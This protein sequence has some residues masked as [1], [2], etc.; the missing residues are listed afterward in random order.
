MKKLSFSFF[1]LALLLGSG[2]LPAQKIHSTKAKPFFD[3]IAKTHK[4]PVANHKSNVIYTPAWAID[5]D[6]TGS[7][8]DSLEHHNYSYY[9]TGEMQVDSISYYPSPLYPNQRIENFFD[10]NNRISSTVYQNWSG[11]QWVNNNKYAML[12]NSND[13]QTLYAGMNWNLGTMA[14]DTN[15]ATRTTY[16]YD[17]NNNNTQILSENWVS[18]GVYEYG[19]RSTYTYDA[20]NN[21]LTE[22]Q[23][24]WSG[25]AWENV[26]KMTLTYNVANE[27]TDMVMQDWVLTA[28]VNSTHVY[29]ISWYNVAEDLPIS[30]T[31]QSWVLGAWVD[32]ERVNYIYG[33]NDSYV[34]TG[35]LWT[36]TAWAM[37]WR[38]T[39]RFDNNDNYTMSMEEFYFGS[40]WTIEYADS[41][42]YLYDGNGNILQEIFVYYDTDSLAYYNFE[43]SLYGNYEVAIE[44]PVVSQDLK[45]YPNPFTNEIRFDYSGAL[46]ANAGLYDLNGRLLRVQEIKNE[47]L[48][49]IYIEGLP[50]AVYMLRA[51]EQC[52]RLLAE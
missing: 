3:A 5:F 42:A 38:E 8:W 20:N 46:P 45:A 30:Y 15:Y 9:W 31:T 21:M 18:N 10:A 22:I 29:N 25:T 4:K 27:P 47:G 39:E 51:G 44:K 34:G 14:W 7:A 32:E 6:W 13:D 1:F 17:G 19:D 36:G 41:A 23:E 37:D 12:Y 48:Q 2:T 43:K 24:D 28:W 40:V 50:K 26:Y 33:N 16:T 49:S 11:G 35:E 52:Q